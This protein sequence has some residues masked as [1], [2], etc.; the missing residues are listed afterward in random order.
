MHVDARSVQ[1]LR[2]SIVRSRLAPY[3]E[4][5]YRM[6]TEA[7]TERMNEA[8]EALPALQALIAKYKEGIA[9]RYIHARFFDGAWIIERVEGTR[10][11]IQFIIEAGDVEWGDYVTYVPR[12]DEEVSIQDEQPF[13]IYDDLSADM[14]G[15]AGGTVDDA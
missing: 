7:D 9:G 10:E 5:M 1:N 8:R 6:R 11:A 2:E 3:H 14:A 15:A 12:A 4:R 13:H